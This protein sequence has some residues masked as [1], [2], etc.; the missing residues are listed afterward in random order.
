MIINATYLKVEEEFVKNSKLNIFAWI[1]AI[2]YFGFNKPKERYLRL[3]FETDKA[4]PYDVAFR[5]FN[6]YKLTIEELKEII[7]NYKEENNW[8]EF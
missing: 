6:D 3:R 2:S 4:L 8:D 5:M 1:K 7:S